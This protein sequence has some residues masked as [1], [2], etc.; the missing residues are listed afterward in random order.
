MLALQAQNV[1]EHTQTD[2]ESKKTTGLG[3]KVRSGSNLAAMTVEQQNGQNNQQR[4]QQFKEQI[5]ATQGFDL[6]KISTHYNHRRMLRRE[7]M[8]FRYGELAPLR[9]MND[10]QGFLPNVLSFA[11]Y[12]LMETAIVATNLSE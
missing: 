8:V 9:S 6:S 2:E 7:K 4:E 10:E 5:G 11:R 12:T 1:D 3:V